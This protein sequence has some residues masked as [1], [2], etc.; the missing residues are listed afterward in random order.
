M[1]LFRIGDQVRIDG[2]TVD[3]STPESVF[4][5]VGTISCEYEPRIWRVRMADGKRWFVHEKD[6]SLVMAVGL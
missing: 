1:S 6:L 3:L 4:G 2:N 5:S